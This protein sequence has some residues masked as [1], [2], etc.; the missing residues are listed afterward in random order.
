MKVLSALNLALTLLAIGVLVLTPLA[1]P[2]M[3]LPVNMQVVMQG[4]MSEQAVPDSGM[5][6]AT[7]HPDMPCCPDRIPASDCGKDCPLVALCMAA[8]TLTTRA[9]VPAFVGRL[10]GIARPGNDADL[11]SLRRRPPPRPPKA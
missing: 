3:A 7:P 4:V 11:D 5:T 1:R 9:G 8:G 6:M 10:T 2:A